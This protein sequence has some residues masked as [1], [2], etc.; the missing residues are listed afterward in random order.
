MPFRTTSSGRGDSPP[1]PPSRPPTPTQQPHCYRGE[2]S[3]Q[4]PGPASR[5]TLT[6]QLP[7][8]PSLLHHALTSTDQPVPCR[9]GTPQEADGSWSG[10]IPFL[11]CLCST[12]K[13]SVQ[14][15]HDPG[16][17][18]TLH[19]HGQVTQASVSGA[20]GSR[21]DGRTGLTSAHSLH[22]EGKGVEPGQ[23]L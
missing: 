15:S 14:A 21:G 22:S 10:Q 9:V 7:G 8:S 19:S 20:L 3:G 12:W 18:Q 5:F 16:E 4:L 23:C 17:Q 11:L 13:S 2:P 6:Q 1:A